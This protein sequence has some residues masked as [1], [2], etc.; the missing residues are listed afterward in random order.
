MKPTAKRAALDVW[1]AAA[2]GLLEEQRR[3]SISPSTVAPGPGAHRECSARLWE[4]EDGLATVLERLLLDPGRW[5]LIFE[6]GANTARYVQFIAFEDGSLVAETV[7]NH[8]L[9]DDSRWAPESEAALRTLGWSDP[10][11]PRSPNWLVVWP[12]RSPSIAEITAL[13]VATLRR[14]LALG[15]RDRVT[16][17]LHSSPRRGGT[18][19]SETPLADNRAHPDVHSAEPTPPPMTAL[20]RFRWGDEPWAD[21]YRSL[22]PGHTHPRNNFD[23]WKYSTTAVNVARALWGARE[24]A[25][26]Q[27][28][29]DHGVDRGPWP[30]D[31]PPVVL[32]LPYIARGACL[33]C[34]WIGGDAAD[35]RRAGRSARNHSISKGDDPMVVRDLRVPI[36]ERGG[37][38]DE[39]LGEKW[40]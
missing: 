5:I 30:V 14:V 22:F 33:N 10:E 34:T 18:P 37:A 15:D 11:A 12:T 40:V 4:I 1:F 8:F 17:K 21:Y 6:H 23:A 13:I 27:W 9:S 36:S 38:A 39:P 7:S 19:A 32:W 20:D 31:H 2:D 25:L 35:L 29:R 24:R 26:R 3:R 28:E 16:V